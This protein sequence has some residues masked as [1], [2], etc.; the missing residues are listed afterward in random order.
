M[1]NVIL[2]IAYVIT[3]IL[4][5]NSIPNNGAYSYKKFGYIVESGLVKWHLSVASISVMNP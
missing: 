4:G 2:M 5:C 1:H 3:Y